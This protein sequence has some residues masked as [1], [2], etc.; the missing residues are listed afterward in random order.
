M[1]LPSAAAFLSG[2]T[3]PSVKSTDM[4]MTTLQDNIVESENFFKS[5][6]T[7]RILLDY[8]K[9]NLMSHKGAWLLLKLE[10]SSI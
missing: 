4:K 1:Y 3:L 9:H 10:V 5:S 6:I 2:L 7:F 8:A